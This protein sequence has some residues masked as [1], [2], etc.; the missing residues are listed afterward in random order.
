MSP[1]LL[2]WRDV[3]SSF[4]GETLISHSHYS[5]LVYHQVHH[6]LKSLKLISL[7]VY[8][9]KPAG[10]AG[11]ITAIQRAALFLNFMSM[12]H[13]V[14]S[15]HQRWCFGING[16][17]ALRLSNIYSHLFSFNIIPAKSAHEQA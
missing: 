7:L 1:F 2:T 4:K 6:E 3:C 8:E 10:D 14:L 17:H 16:S 13:K 9:E 11:M 12:Y 5:R 15:V